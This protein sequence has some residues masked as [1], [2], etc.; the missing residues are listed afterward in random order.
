[1]A[2]SVTSKVLHDAICPVWTA[3]HT[4]T[5]R[6]SHLP[7]RVLCAVDG[8][9]KSAALL[10]WAD[11]F[12]RRLDGRLSVVHVVGPIT[13]WPSLDRERE[14]QE[15][16]RDDARTHLVKALQGAG[17]T[18]PVRVAV[19]EIVNTVV[20][21]ARQDQADL[22]IIGR[23]AITEPLGRLRTHAFGIVQRSP[24]PVLSV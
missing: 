2:G 20:E 6:S 7:Q 22:V 24:C 13:D 4:E 11:A 9:S 18:I 16:V 1:L 8:T 21:E 23:G 17:L 3:A 19:G 5:Q 15:E 10:Q 12:C 14:L